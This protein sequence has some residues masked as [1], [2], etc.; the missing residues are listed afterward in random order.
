M[1]QRIASFFSHV[2]LLPRIDPVFEELFVDKNEYYRADIRDWTLDG[3]FVALAYESDLKQELGAYKY[4]GRKH[5]KD[6][7]L[8]YL[9]KCFDLFITEHIDRS[10]IIT[11]APL[12]VLSRLQRGYNQSALLAR[13]IAK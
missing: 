2:F 9:R 6:L 11:S 3:T 13:D 10:A 12:F 7:F 1:I 8:P 5:K 4:F